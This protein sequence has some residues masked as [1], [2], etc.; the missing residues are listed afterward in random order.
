MTVKQRCRVLVGI[1]FEDRRWEPGAVIV[2]DN[3]LWKGKV[4]TGAS[5]RSTE[6]IR[7]FNERLM[8]DPRLASI[9]LPIGDGASVSV[10]AA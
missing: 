2:A 10:V 4:A 8:T 6:A 3:V 5:D 1:N 7:R 9:I